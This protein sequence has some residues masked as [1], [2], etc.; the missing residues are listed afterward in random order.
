MPTNTKEK[1]GQKALIVLIILII[2]LLGV[3]V[4]FLFFFKRPTQ[5]VETQKP[6]ANQQQNPISLPE[7]YPEA[8]STKELVVNADPNAQEAPKKEVDMANLEKMASLFA[9]R[10][11][12]YSNQSDYGNFT[13]LTIIMTES[14]RKWATDYVEN[15]KKTFKYD[16]IYRG[17]MTKAVSAKVSDFDEVAGTAKAVVSTQKVETADDKPDKVVYYEDMSITFKKVDSV[18]LVDYAKW[19]GRK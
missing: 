19:Q 6:Q 15:A 5:T 1:D 8:T 10:L 2:L 3:L 13:D 11:G 7:S 18:W 12:S 16:G 4:W 17:T 14:M 9:E